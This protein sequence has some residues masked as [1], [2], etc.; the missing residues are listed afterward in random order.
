MDREIKRLRKKFI[1]LSAGISLLVLV[2]MLFTLNLLMRAPYQKEK[3]A[4]AEVLLQT[5]RNHAPDLDTESF[6]LSALE[7]N[8]DGDWIIP[9]SPSRIAEV[10]LHGS[11]RC[12][13]PDTSWYCAGGGLLFA[14]K[15]S[16]GQPQYVHKEYSF[17]RDNTEITIPVAGAA[18]TD[19]TGNIF[20]ADAAALDDT[21]FMVS[22]VWW[23]SSSDMFAAQPPEITLTLERVEIRYREEASAAAH[24]QYPVVTR[25]L[26]AV[27]PDGLPETLGSCRC[28]YLIT[29]KTGNLAEVNSG[30]MQSPVSEEAARALLQTGATSGYV[31]DGVTYD[32]VTEET[33]T[34]RV[35]AFFDNAQ[36]TKSTR[37]LLRMSVLSGGGI[38]LL[39]LLLIVLVSK[40]AV[41]PV[42]ES[43]Q[44]QTQFISNASHELKTPITV[45]AATTE[46]ME[47]K[48]GADRLTECL[49]TQTEKMS[50][51]VNEMLALTRLAEPDNREIA[52]ERFD[53]SRTVSHA[54]LSFEGMAYEAGKQLQAE[55]TPGL[56][57]NGSADKIDALVGILLD[58]A[59]KYSDTG[60]EIRMQLF[61]K[62]DKAV[63]VC[64]N[65]CSDFSADAI[66]FLFDRFYRADVSHS[67]EKAGFG[68]GL[69]IAKEIVTR[70]GGEIHV[71]Y[72]DGTVEVRVVLS[73]SA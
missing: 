17:N 52:S 34:Q 69:S 51:L 64:T 22:I 27:Y 37:R 56:F 47:T 3:K 31:L 39:V 42:Q 71:R 18:L 1:G 48:N 65:P 45:I 66:P 72:Q 11:I 43:Y 19:E 26:D 36:I 44:R 50:R 63:L 24:A 59:L 40:K 41:Q 55:L 29:D 35:Y 23:T 15:G 28:F 20:P 10:T 9:R 16:G 30:T 7:T 53:L 57:C 68:L 54:V 4:A 58:N 6:A 49:T 14:Q 5:A 62:K 60:A 8:E 12:G 33:D 32:C 61:A 25:G 67:D 21:Y 46:L 38:Y 2:L 73:V 13:N 70:H